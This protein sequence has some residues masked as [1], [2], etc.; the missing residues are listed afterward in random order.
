MAGSKRLFKYIDDAGEAYSVLLDESNS[1]G[2]VGATAL[3][4]NRSATHPEK[5]QSLKF[6]YILATL[7]SNPTIK[8]KFWVGDPAVLIGIFSGAILNA[9]VYPVSGDT[10]P[11]IAQWTV[12]RFVGESRRI[13]EALNNTGG[14]TGLTDG[15]FQLDE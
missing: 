7:I 11:S 6:R 12:T 14:D 8:R 4:Q 10:A 3:F 1:E 2:Y 9:N 5:P 15:D 13:I